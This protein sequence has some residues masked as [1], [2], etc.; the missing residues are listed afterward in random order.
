[1]DAISAGP[2]PAKP[3]EVDALIERGRAAEPLSTELSTYPQ[4]STDRDPPHLMRF[5]AV[6]GSDDR[7]RSA[8]AR[9]RSSI[10]R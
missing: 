7:N 6:D 10:G 1:V 4:S 3:R 8:S 5:S 9:A 2:G